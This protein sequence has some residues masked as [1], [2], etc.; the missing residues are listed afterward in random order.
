M[1]A[2]FSRTILA[3]AAITV[4]FVG[5]ALG[6]YQQSRPQNHSGFWF[7]AGLGYGSLGCQN[8]TGRTGGLSGNLALGGSL[9]QRLLLGVASNGWVKSENGTTL[10]VNSITAAVRFYPAVRSGFFLMGGLGVGFVSA[11]FSGG[12]A[13]ESGVGALLGLGYDIRLAHSISL[14]PYW[15]GF[16]MNSSNVDAN[17]GQIG[18]GITVR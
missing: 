18:L 12:S 10:S 4:S 3:L 8:C 7:S 1:N 13:S 14:T 5:N 17:V 2:K 15:N 11:G 6:Q 9:S 16:A